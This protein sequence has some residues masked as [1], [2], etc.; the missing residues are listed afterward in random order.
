MIG[1]ALNVVRSR[2][3]RKLRLVLQVR[4]LRPKQRERS[5]RLN[6]RRL[7][8]PRLDDLLRFHVVGGTSFD[9]ETTVQHPRAGSVTM[10][11]RHYRP[12]EALSGLG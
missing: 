12:G 6:E 5:P 3:E 7:G 11:A 10:T 1:V 4:V 2:A 9:V 8:S